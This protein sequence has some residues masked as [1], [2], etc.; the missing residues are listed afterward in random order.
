MAVLVTVKGAYRILSWEAA[1]CLDP[2]TCLQISEVYKEALPVLSHVYT[3]Q[4]FAT[5]HH[6]F[7]AMSLGQPLGVVKACGE[8][9]FHGLGRV[10]SL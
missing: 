5:A 4:V 8:A 2:C 9:T 7:E 3:M 1:R 10:R 6:H